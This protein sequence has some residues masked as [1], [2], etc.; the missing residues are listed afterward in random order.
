MANSLD[1][2]I[3]LAQ[4]SF[5]DG[6]AN[7]TELYAECCQVLDYE[8]GQ[9]RL[10]AANAGGVPTEVTGA[11]TS[12]SAT[13]L[14]S[15]IKVV[16]QRAFALKHRM[17]RAQ[18]NWSQDTLASDIGS[19]LANSAAAAINK[20][21]FDG[22]EGLFAL[23]HP[24]AGA[25]AGEVGAGKKFLATGLKYAQTTGNEGTQDNLLTDAL[26]ENALNAARALLRRYKNQQAVPMNMGDGNYVLVVGP[27]NEKLAKQ[28][29]ESDM[30]SAALQK[31]T[32][33]NWARPIV[34][35][36]A[37]DDDDWWVI[38]V[39]KSPV[40]IWLGQPPMIT[41]TPSEDEIFVNF[42]AQFEAS[43]Y[44]KAYE[45]GIIGSNVA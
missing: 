43:F 31:N 19:Q 35:P 29:L 11:T 16:T 18:L 45:Y 32:L 12:V 25:G 7:A 5:M 42:T 30:T 41:V 39:D 27:G 37:S 4:A 17:P 34:Y 8:G 26:S 23:A 21:Y 20:L 38:D 6:L 14:T 44:T 13:D 1:N 9:A 15:G 24:M 28:L 22:L 36:L 10:M 2:V 40:G 3:K 33:R